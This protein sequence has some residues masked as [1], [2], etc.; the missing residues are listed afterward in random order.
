[1]AGMAG[2][3]IE[4]LYLQNFSSKVE[5][6][7]SWAVGWWIT[8]DGYFVTKKW[9][10]FKFPI[11]NYVFVPLDKVYRTIETPKQHVMDL[12]HCRINK[13]KKPFQNPK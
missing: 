6:T 5:L 7:L 1:M 4:I 12:C 3:T 2:E 9:Y 13:E 11:W 10:L 8:E